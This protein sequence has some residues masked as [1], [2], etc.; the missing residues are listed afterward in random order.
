MKITITSIRL[1]SP[2]KFFPL[3]LYALHI[4]RQLKSTN[5]AEFKK[6]G[7]WTMH[8][9]MTMWRSEEDLKVFATSGAHLK[10]MQ[11]G[12]SIAS[13]ISTL[14]IDAEQ[15]P[16]WKTAKEMLRKDGKVTRYFQS[17]P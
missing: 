15:L 11:K 4:M 13:E 17:E 3:S 2:F 10:A 6:T 8:Y 12:A 5:Y 16:D 14:T 9:T 7:L 1:R